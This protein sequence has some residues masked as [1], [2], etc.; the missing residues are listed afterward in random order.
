MLKEPK[1]A[2]SI[3]IKQQLLEFVDI[4]SH[5]KRY[6]RSQ[7][8]DYIIMEYQKILKRKNLERTKHQRDIIDQEKK[9]SKTIYKY[10]KGVPTNE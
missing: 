7:T 2:I 8:I 5:A 1:V 9:M 6:N 10:Q 4:I 3:T